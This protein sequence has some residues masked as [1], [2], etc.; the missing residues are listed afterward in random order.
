MSELNLV[1]DTELEQFN[2]SVSATGT[3]TNS[4][5]K[6]NMSYDRTESTTI[7]E[8]ELEGV[9][10]V[11]ISDNQDSQNKIKA[12]SG[13][14]NSPNSKIVFKTKPLSEYRGQLNTN[15]CANKG[16]YILATYET[17]D[18][19]LPFKML[20]DSGSSMSL[21]HKDMYAKL[22]EWAKL[23]IIETGKKIRFADG[24]IQESCGIVNIPLQI[25]DQNIHVDFCLDHTLMMRY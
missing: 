1:T 17:D 3:E 12:N 19:A 11:S 8:V 21:L 20:L 10:E 6:T 4:E 14:M 23:P 22:P 5:T 18:V 7:H 9:H 16:L 2:T 25:G 13:E 15:A 24:S